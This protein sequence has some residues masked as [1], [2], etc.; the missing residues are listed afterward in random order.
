M[1][2][3]NRWMSS[4]SLLTVTAVVILVLLHQ[5]FVVDHYKR[6]SQENTKKLTKDIE[7]K[8]LKYSLLVNGTKASADNMY[9]YRPGYKIN[10]EPLYYVDK[11]QKD[12]V[13]QLSTYYVAGE[14]ARRYN[15]RYLID[16]GC[17]SGVKMAS[18]RDEFHVIGIDYE[19]N[20]RNATKAFPNLQFIEANLEGD[21]ECTVALSPEILSQAVVVSADII[22]HLKNPLP[23]YVKTLKKF[24]KYA[25]AIVISTPD[26]AKIKNVNGGS[27]YDGPPS[28]TA[29]V[30]EWLNAELELL[31]L[32][33]GM[34]PMYSGLSCGQMVNCG[35]GWQPNTTYQSNQIHILGNEQVRASWL[36]GDYGPSDV[37]AFVVHERST[38]VELLNFNVKYLTE[39][40]IK[41]NV[42]S[43]EASV[44]SMTNT[45]VHPAQNR[46]DAFDVISRLCEENA[47]QLGDWFII[48][49][50]NDVINFHQ[51]D[52]LQ[53]N[54][55]ETLRRIGSEPY[56]FN[57]VAMTTFFMQ[58]PEGAEWGPSMPFK[59]FSHGVWNPKT[60]ENDRL[61]PAVDTLKDRVRIWRKSTEPLEIKMGET[62]SGAEIVTGVAFL[63]RRVYPYHAL[64][65]RFHPQFKN[66]Y[67]DIDNELRRIYNLDIAI[68]YQSDGRQPI[69]VDHYLY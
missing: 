9:I 35:W 10:A 60:G 38:A 55:K 48:M 28:N 39:Q 5:Y 44:P 7:R 26:A 54:L 31:F 41:V 33:Q 34:Y 49:D 57:A 23:C 61:W 58:S 66:P 27:G 50:S 43:I 1:V 6:N 36:V 46:R 19:T 37:I 15:A 24:S 53:L 63:G 67:S 25:A 11:G 51:S 29:H 69:L 40:G 12:L 30:R 45:K 64:D 47:Y 8:A 65:L 22:E 16:V 2:L 18:F 17:G 52:A 32:D 14:L 56:G 59:I 13:F 21:S 42:I 4:A 20:I 3:L 68:N 62:E